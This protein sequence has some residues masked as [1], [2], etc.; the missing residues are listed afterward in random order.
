MSGAAPRSILSSDVLA[1]T[2]LAAAYGALLMA[3]AL[4]GRWFRPLACL[5]TAFGTGAYLAWRY[6]T[7]GDGLAAGGAQRSFTLLC[8]AF[9]TLFIAEFWTF[10]LLVSRWRDRRPEADAH[11]RR[12]RRRGVE[13]LPAVDVFI[14][15][16]NEEFD[17]LE[18]SII[19]ALQLD[20]PKA[21]VHVL[22]DGRREWL[23]D[24]CAT[25]GARYIARP[26]NR[27]KK[28]GN[29]NYALAR[30]SAPFIAVF[31]ADFVPYR[32]FLWRTLGFF[33]TPE[34][35][36]IQTPQ[37]FFNKDTFQSNLLLQNLLPDEQR[38]FFSHVMPCR[39][40]W[41]TA[42]YC[43]SAAVLRRAAIE[44]IGGIVRGHATEDNVTSV[45]L[46]A[47]GY[48]TLYL[49]EQLSWG[50]APESSWAFLEQRK[51]WCRGGVQVLFRRDGP[52][53]P[54]MRPWHRRLFFLPLHWLLGF[55]SP[56]YFVAIALIPWYFDL[57]PFFGIPPEG[58]L[59][60]TLLVTLVFSHMLLWLGRG[61]WLPVISPATNLFQ[62][63]TLV[64]IA[65]STLMKPFGRPL[66]DF[67]EVT[68]KGRAAAAGRVNWAV[69]TPLVVAFL[70]LCLG[71][72]KT[73]L[74]DSY[75]RD[76]GEI[77]TNTIWSIFFAAHLAIA[78]VAAME[79]PY[80][81]AEE[82][83]EISVPGVLLTEDGAA[84]PCR[85]AD[86]SLGGARI[87]CAVAAQRCRLQAEGETLAAETVWSLGGVAA[88][89]F[90]ALT[91]EQRRRLIA[92][93]YTANRRPP[94]AMKYLQIVNGTLKRLIYP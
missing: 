23:R 24:F 94:F 35:G 16:Y 10:L 62:S 58:S 43:G 17:V 65:L 30:T 34:I 41:G 42:F 44:A 38:F 77:V 45:A 22:D 84:L 6:I 59:P 37:A 27:D 54:L 32:N 33:E 36:I 15:T 55:V 57:S 13:D 83:F 51:R 31:D 75:D 49:N 87:D 90:P 82:R 9:E 68:P 70:L 61:S 63:L 64:P 85:V 79:L 28:A 50:L 7:A 60:A 11:E 20:Y 19:G 14:T 47:K 3:S 88:L 53:G 29:H 56:I 4:P 67:V 8:L 39:D 21:T 5:A 74:L 89:R 81:R 25:V 66:L 73:M 48:R 1:L 46:L 76:V 80:R 26:D 72:G 78:G 91:A 52:L 2:A 93:L 71:M 40:A 69:L 92:R 12:L 86:M 18:K